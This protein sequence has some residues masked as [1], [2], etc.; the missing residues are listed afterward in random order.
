MSQTALAQRDSIRTIED[1]NI[2]TLYKPNVAE[3]NKIDI[4]PTL[5]EPKYQPPIFNYSFS[6]LVFKPKSVYS[7]ANAILLRPEKDDILKDNYLRAAGGNYLTGIIDARYFSN[8]GKNINYGIDFKHHS[9]NLSNNPAMGT[10]NRN[11]INA[12]GERTT[13][14]TIRGDIFFDR[15]AV[16]YYG[17]DTSRDFKK[18][19]LKQA[20]NLASATLSL[21][22]AKKG[23]LSTSLIGDVNFLNSNN[24]SELSVGGKNITSIELPKNQKFN[25]LL[26]V[27]YNK[28]SRDTGINRLFVDLAPS[29]TFEINRL[30]VDLGIIVNYYGD[31][32]TSKIYAAPN[33]RA[34]TFLVPKKIKAFAAITG[35]LIQNTMQSFIYQ[36][37]FLNESFLLR[38]S[39]EMYR[40]SLGMDGKLN[41]VFEYGLSISQNSIE[42]MAFFVND[43]NDFRNLTTLYDDVNTF[44]FQ[45][46][47]KFTLNN[48]INLGGQ[49]NTYTYNLTSENQA[50][51]MPKFDANI[52][53]NFQVADK[54]Y[55]NCNFYHVGER[56]ARDLANNT[57]NIGGINDISL[58][59]EYR[60]KKNIS[61]F[62]R[63]NN[64]LNQRYAL[65][66]HHLSQGLNALAGFT[67]TL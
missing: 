37:L 6:D 41:K 17:A 1:V 65:W 46:R 55:F 8:T 25:N 7:P 12:F 45:G 5:K 66:N 38:N 36:N 61:F 26:S 48:K 54:I 62:G 19:T 58:A 56:F 14:A 59:A 18:D 42:D 22:E 40:L 63:V 28:V 3:A 32:S 47:V 9:S 49:F 67:I 4:L 50:W 15:N 24:A 57:F 43:T 29:Y 21:L 2:V 11:R 23:K 30:A 60:Y 31:N 20:Y 34:E 39:R 33:L 16:H 27:L 44:N 10:F 51:H 52:F 53:F 35:G 64:V 13:N